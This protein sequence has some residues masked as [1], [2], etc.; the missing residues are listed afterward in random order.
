[1]VETRTVV[2]VSAASAAVVIAGYLIYFDYKRRNDT[3]FRKKLRKF[4]GYGPSFSAHDLPGK[5]KK[6]AAKNAKEGESAAPAEPSRSQEELKELLAKI[7][8]EPLPTLPAEREKYF[9]DHVGMGEQLL[10]KGQIH[11]M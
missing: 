6:K 1:M 2:A 4:Q 3:S 10:L 11:Y 7:N 8:A 5:E 9:M